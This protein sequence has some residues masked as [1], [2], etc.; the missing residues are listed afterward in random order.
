MARLS[1]YYHRKRMKALIT[2]FGA[3]SIIVATSSG[4]E[5]KVDIVQAIRA[6]DA[7]LKVHRNVMQRI[8][9]LNVSYSGV[10]V[11]RS[12]HRGWAFLNA[13]HPRAE[14]FEN[15]SVHPL[16]GRAEGINLISINF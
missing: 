7:S 9:G 1:I 13:D 5:T 10:L 4:Q 8:F 6:R 16:T 12:K 14:P 15:G 11:P 3:L 2:F